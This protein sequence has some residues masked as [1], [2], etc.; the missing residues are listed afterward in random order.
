M[1]NRI[2]TKRN[3]YLLGSLEAIA[4]LIWLI[5]IPGKQEN[6]WVLGFSLNRWLILI[7][8]ILISLVFIWNLSLSFR[9]DNRKSLFESMVSQRKILVPVVLISVFILF[10]GI[11]VVILV[12]I[13]SLPEFLNSFSKE[14]NKDHLSYLI[15]S[16]TKRFLPLILLIFSLC[17][18]TLLFLGKDKQVLINKRAVV[19]EEE[20]N[21]NR[22]TVKEMIRSKPDVIAIILLSL[23]LAILFWLPIS[24]IFKI[25]GPSD[26]R[27]YIRFAMETAEGK[28]LDPHFLYPLLVI[29]VQFIPGVDYLLSAMLVVTAFFSVSGILI[30]FYIRPSMGPVNSAKHS[31]LSLICSI[32]LLV[33]TPIF[34]F[35][36]FNNNLYRGYIGISIYH[37]PTS[38]L[39]KPFA[40]LVFLF[41]MKVFLEKSTQ[42]KTVT[43]AILIILSTLAKP[44]YTIVLFPAIGL[45]VIY[46][47]IKK[48]FVQWKPLIF[49]IGIPSV[50]VLGWQY[51][52]FFGQDIRSKILFSPLESI[53]AWESNNSLILLKFIFSIAF[54]LCVYV[55]DLKN[56]K[57]NFGLNLSWLI[58]FI[59]SFYLYFLIQIGPEQTRAGNFLWSAQLGLFILFLVSAKHLID[60]NRNFVSTA[61]PKRLIK[62]VFTYSIFGLH[63]LCGIYFYY[64]HLIQNSLK[65]V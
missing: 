22:L 16:Y 30:Y 45:V 2:M 35:T 21:S 53:K 42:G 20:V 65:L 62:I 11:I 10:Y 4:S 63:L 33:V 57:R 52:F 36:L 50:V 7:P 25:S 15:S 27:E 47:I 39:L 29:I 48:R 38:L 17:A 34:I 44:S 43:L 5:S 40:I 12:N 56:A 60:N 26:Y 49:G 54:P 51:F 14:N 8:I 46:R 24:N 61:P 37:N 31:I 6:A 32:S 19:I 58:F 28:R 59:G 41:T 23:L 1:K 64:W 18:Q 13:E 55:F 3:Y 9:R